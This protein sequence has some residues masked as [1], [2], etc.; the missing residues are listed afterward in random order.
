MSKPLNQFSHPMPPHRSPHS[1]KLAFEL[2]D[3]I[4]VASSSFTTPDRPQLHSTLTTLRSLVSLYEDQRSWV[5]RQRTSLDDSLPSPDDISQDPD[6]LLPDQDVQVKTEPLDHP[7]P[8]VSKT[9]ATTSFTTQKSESTLL[10]QCILPGIETLTQ[11]GINKDAHI[12][13]IFEEMMEAR[14][15][16]CHRID[17]LVR[18]A[19]KRSMLPLNVDLRQRLVSVPVSIPVGQDDRPKDGTAS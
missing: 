9:R 4:P 16:S 17:R 11:A 2:R 18:N 8:T 12:L 3:D 19:K 7:V 10:Q 13:D 1:P 6:P 14:L 15:E 5:Y